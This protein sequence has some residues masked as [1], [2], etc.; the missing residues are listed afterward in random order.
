MNTLKLH[1]KYIQRHVDPVQ[2]ERETSR[3][4][5]VYVYCTELAVEWLIQNGAQMLLK[6]CRNAVYKICN[7]NQDDL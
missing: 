6:Y 4:S 3:R 7:I 2:R 5:L 1:L